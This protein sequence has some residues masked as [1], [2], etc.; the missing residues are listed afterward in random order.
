M[1]FFKINFPNFTV[2]SPPTF[3]IYEFQILFLQ[4]SS[5]KVHSTVFNWNFLPRNM[6]LIF[7]SLSLYSSFFVRKMRNENFLPSPKSLP[8][9]GRWW[10]FPLFYWHSFPS[11]ILLSFSGMLRTLSSLKIFCDN[12]HSS[13]MS[14]GEWRK[15]RN[16]MRVEWL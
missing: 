12:F 9:S 2:S 1:V 5:C 3:S 7:L 11:F 15:E 10:N 14:Q 8:T 4:I 6:R 16:E 13:L